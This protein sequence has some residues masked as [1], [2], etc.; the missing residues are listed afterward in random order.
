[1][2]RKT[3]FQDDEILQ[4]IPQRAPFVM[5]DK[6]YEID[7]QRLLSGLQLHP[8]NVLCENGF[9]SA[10]GLV[11]NIAQSAALF[12]G[13]GFRNRG[14]NVPLGFIASIKDLTIE[15]L[16]EK[17]AALQT[18]IIFQKEIMNMHIVTGT[19]FDVHLNKLANCELRI[20]IKAEN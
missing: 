9:F 16:P 2:T 19:V 15:K 14:E 10:G 18:E 13:Y 3:L 5:I 1:M 17:D 11:E 20:F 7:E 12:A 8:D 6:V 4:F